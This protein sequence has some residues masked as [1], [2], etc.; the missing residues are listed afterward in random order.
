MSYIALDFG[1][2]DRV[3]DLGVVVDAERAHHVSSVLLILLL[4]FHLLVGSNVQLLG[5]TLTVWK[6]VNMS[7]TMCTYVTGDVCVSTGC[8][9]RNRIALH[10]KLLGFVF[11]PIVL[12]AILQ[13]NNC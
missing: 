12:V 2:V 7:A 1:H 8:K 13:I 11:F 4:V 5:N 9:D 10:L 3:Q 6:T